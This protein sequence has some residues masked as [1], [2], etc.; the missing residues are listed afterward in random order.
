MLLSSLHYLDVYGYVPFISLYYLDVYGYAPRSLWV[1]SIHQ[2]ILLRCLWLVVTSLHRCLIL[3]FQI[4]LDGNRLTELTPS[5]AELKQLK[6]LFLSDNHLSSLPID[7]F[8]KVP[9][10]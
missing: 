2:S 5:L 8:D 3:S 7:I 9:M 1:H 10:L 6:F 4:D